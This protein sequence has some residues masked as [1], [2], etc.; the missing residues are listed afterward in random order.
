MAPDRDMHKPTEIDSL[1]E[2]AKFVDLL[3]RSPVAAKIAKVVVFGSVVKGTAG[4]GSDVDLLV[5][6]L[7]G[8]AVAE[9]IADV[10]LDFQMES[11]API[12]F[13][14]CRVSDLW[15]VTDYFFVNVLRYGKEIYS[16]PNEEIKTAAVRKLLLLAR[17]Y[18]QASEETM[19]GGRHRL[20][21]DGAYNAAELAAKGLMLLEVDDLPGSHGG[22][23]QLFGSLYVQS[24]QLDRDIGRQLHLSLD[25]RNAAR[26]Q[27]DAKLSREDAEAVISLAK[28]LLAELETRLLPR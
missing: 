21:I 6:T 10:L 20:A 24:G 7:D 26:Y 1:R 15:P 5:V 23:V 4:P 13:L 22:I 11:R 9:Q 27:P 28:R 12:E 2:V 14:T 19:E 25:R 18:L 16:M 17:D 3:L 8:E